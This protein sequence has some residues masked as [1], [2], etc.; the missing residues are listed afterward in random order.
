[1]ATREIR[2]TPCSLDCFDACGIV[3]EVA[4]GCIVRL[5]G[6]AYNQNDVRLES[7]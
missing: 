3:A 5:G 7:A 6:T 1:M 4:E 2:R